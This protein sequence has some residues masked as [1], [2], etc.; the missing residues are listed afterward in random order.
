MISVQSVGADDP[1][2]VALWQELDA[3]LG[4]RYGEPELVTPISPDGIVVVILALSEADEPIGTVLLRWSRDHP[5]RPGTVEIKRLYVRSE[6]RG[7]G[8]ARVMM[9]AIERAAFRVGATRLVLATGQAQ[10]EAVAL[11]TGIGYTRI[12][13]FGTH[14][15]DARSI[16]MAKSLPTRLLVVN[17]AMGAGKTA[18]GSAIVDVLSDAGVRV[19]FIDAD[20][21]CQ[22]RPEPVN[23]PFQQHLMWL[24]VTALAP[25][26]RARGYGC[27]VVARAVEDPEDRNRYARVFA[28]RV[29]PAQVSVVR[30]TVADETRVE[31]LTAREP[32]GRRRDLSIARSRELDEILDGIDL[33]DGV[34]ATDATPSQEVARQILD[35]AGWWVP[36]AENLAQ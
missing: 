29:G 16:C 3:E 1:R 10:P 25:I 6:H 19:A 17:G 2:A 28:S 11:Y 5:D 9:G 18:A 36:G 22:A 26:Y 21:L 33:D 32:V 35:V 8:H 27:V 12:P 4:H 14:A 30:V 23:D 24:N 31:R 13:S 15:A 20:T 7:H 34:V